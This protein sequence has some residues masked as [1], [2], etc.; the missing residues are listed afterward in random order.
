MQFQ[1]YWL[2]NDPEIN[3]ML[4][5]TKYLGLS[6][7]KYFFVFRPFS[8]KFLEIP[9][10]ISKKY[11]SHFSIHIVRFHF[12]S[13]FRCIWPWNAQ[14]AF[15]FARGCCAIW[16]ARTTSSHHQSN[17]SNA[18]RSASKTCWGNPKG[19]MIKCSKCNCEFYTLHSQLLFTVAFFTIAWSS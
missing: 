10:I 6:R 4:L 12:A 17:S 14:I 16:I 1:K 19:L 9:D 18:A 13:C 11:V 3:V 5:S 8:S 15:P 7:L 2:E